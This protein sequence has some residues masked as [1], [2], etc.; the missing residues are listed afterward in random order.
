LG[1]LN[2]WAANA[3]VRI[4]LGIVA[5]A[6]LFEMLTVIVE[7]FLHV[8]LARRAILG[9]SFVEGE[10]V[11][12]Y[13]SPSGTPKLVIESI[14]QTWSSSSLNGQVFLSDG[15]AWG[16]W[17]STVV[18]VEGEKGL[19]RATRVGDLGSG[20]YDS[21]LEHRIDGKP[22]SKISGLVSDVGH[23]GT[24]WMVRKK[25][26]ARLTHAERLQAAKEVCL[27]MGWAV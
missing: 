18:E 2:E 5:S 19:L 3:A 23:A 24:A 7:Q 4:P 13:K 1:D 16:Q 12:G 8:P 27:E 20:Y 9:K 22:P 26:S 14:R 10:W 25:V 6:G 11:G 21:I 15:T 17:H